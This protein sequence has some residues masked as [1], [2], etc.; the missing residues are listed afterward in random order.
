MQLTGCAGAVIR[1][2]HALVTG[3]AGGIGLEISKCLAREGAKAVSIFDIS[4]Q[5]LDEASQL[6]SAG[7]KTKITTCVV[8]VTS[9][10][11]VQ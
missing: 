7:F 10:D 1:D 2:Q 3:G 6:L 11:T 5:A 4:K 9:S 8:D